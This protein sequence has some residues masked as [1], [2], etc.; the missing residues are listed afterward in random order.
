MR[1]GFYRAG[2]HRLGRSDGSLSQENHEA[3]FL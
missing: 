1:E 3:P 2:L